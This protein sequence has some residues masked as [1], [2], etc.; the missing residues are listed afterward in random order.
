MMFV[1]AQIFDAVVRLDR[2]HRFGEHSPIGELANGLRLGDPDAVR[3]TMEASDEAI[4][5]LPVTASAWGAQTRKAVPPSTG[6]APM[7]SIGCSGVVTAGSSRPATGVRD[8]A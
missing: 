8:A 4:T 7:P 5:W 6:M 1:S 2:S 3:A